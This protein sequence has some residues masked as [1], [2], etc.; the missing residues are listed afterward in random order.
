MIFKGVFNHQKLMYLI[1]AISAG[2]IITLAVLNDGSANDNHI[3]VAELILSKKRAP[4]YDEC[5]QCYHPKLYHY[6]LAKTW[7][8]LDINDSWSRIISAQLITA[9]AG[10]ISLLICLRFILTQPFSHT[11]QLLS[12]ILIAFNPRLISTHV[13]P[14]ND[15]FI[16]LFGTIIIFQLYRWLKCPSPFI[17]FTIVLATILASATKGNSFVLITSVSIILLIK[18]IIEKSYNFS[19]RKTSLG[20]FLVFLIITLVSTGY[21]GGYF[22]NYKKHGH[23]FVYN[24]PVGEAPH[25]IKK[26]AFR[27]PGV[28]SVIDGYFTFRFFSMLKTPINSNDY[29]GE[30][31]LH[32][33]SVWTQLY[34]R[35][36]F[37]YFDNWPPGVWQTQSSIIINIGRAT[38]ILA[39]LPSFIFLIVFFK[40]LK[41]WVVF[42]LKNKFDFLRKT[43]DWIFTIFNLSFIGFIILFTAYGRDYSFMKIVYLFPAIIATAN[44][45]MRGFELV[46]NFL[47]KDKILLSFFQANIVILVFFYMIPV[48]DIITKLKDKF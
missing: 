35:T 7:S 36:H 48:I 12:F 44:P 39:L 1:F 2:I 27:R 23:F 4:V 37:I 15:A 38:L 22:S 31:P 19:L 21:L 25:F 6:T 16:I 26:T 42:F 40:T 11:T 14:T 33:T 17:L 32:R 45:L 43:N 30:Y 41:K 13:Q 28:R 46:N 5:W 8:W 3:E 24:T 18:I 20:S 47:R 10:I 34:G 29:G 9:F